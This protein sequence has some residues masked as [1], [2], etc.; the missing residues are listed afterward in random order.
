MDGSAVDGARLA[1][2]SWLVELGAALAEHP[3]TPHL[4]LAYFD[5]YYARCGG[6]TRPGRGPRGHSVQLVAAA[7]FLMATKI[8]E[9]YVPEVDEI[10]TLTAGACSSKAILAAELTV[11]QKLSFTLCMMTTVDALPHLCN[12][13]AGVEEMEENDGGRRKP[14]LVGRVV[15]FADGAELHADE[16]LDGEEKSDE[17]EEAMVFSAPRLL[18]SRLRDSAMAF[19][20]VASHSTG[21]MEMYSVGDVTA[22]C[23]LL[24]RCDVEGADFFGTEWLPIFD[25]GGLNYAVV[26]SAAAVILHTWQK[27]CLIRNENG[28]EDEGM[29][30]AE[31]IGS[32]L[33]SSLNV[34]LSCFSIREQHKFA[35]KLGAVL[36][37]LPPLCAVRVM[38][39]GVPVYDVRVDLEERKISTYATTDSRNAF[40]LFKHKKVLWNSEMRPR[41]LLDLVYSLLLLKDHPSPIL[42]RCQP[43]SVIPENELVTPARKSTSD[44]KRG[45]RAEKSIRKSFTPIRCSTGKE[46]YEATKPRRTSQ[47]LQTQRPSLRANLRSASAPPSKRE[48]ESSSAMSDQRAKHCR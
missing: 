14:C 34:A 35:E 41:A 46:N 20:D 7:S 3:Q 4:A 5:S 21:L 44:S 39:A 9:N 16:V 38:T 10:S 42:R 19:A 37:L 18:A 26:V 47:R 15:D 31:E 22:A 2:V 29:P 32:P 28:S 8:A 33:S 48:R 13:A 11:C 36:G 27:L 23:L 25:Q 6:W 40:V 24:A 12:L 45:L 30:P 43:L 1:V 17:D